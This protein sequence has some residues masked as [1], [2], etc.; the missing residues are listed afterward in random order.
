MCSWFFTFNF[1]FSLFFFPPDI[2][3][4]FAEHICILESFTWWFQYCIPSCCDYIW[5]CTVFLATMLVTE[6][7][8]FTPVSFRLTPHSTVAWPSR[9]LTS[10]ERRWHITLLFQSVLLSNKSVLPWE[11][12]NTILWEIEI[13]FPNVFFSFEFACE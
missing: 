9:V 2:L 7:F 13:S 3:H 10:P 5:S 11:T 8:V 6:R 4:V 1:S 12:E